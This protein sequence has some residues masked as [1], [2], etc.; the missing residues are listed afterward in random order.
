LHGQS[1]S[2][3][4]LALGRAYFEVGELTREIDSMEEAQK[5]MR[6][7][8]ALFK[9]LSHENPADAESRRALALS[10]RSLADTLSAVSRH[11]DALAAHGRSRD[12]FRALAEADPGNRQLRAEWA[13]SEMS[14]AMSLLF[15]QRPASQ[16]LESAERARSVLE[17]TVGPTHGPR[18][19]NPNLRKCSAPWA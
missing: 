8:P 7:A 2:D 3:S 17:V 19:S 16:A 15:N 11:A 5:A 6:R 10:L 18:I 1:D 13:R 9:D 12:L 4:R 14:C